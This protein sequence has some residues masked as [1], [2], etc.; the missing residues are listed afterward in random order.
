MSHS[1]MVRIPPH[2][3]VPVTP[4]VRRVID[5]PEMRRLSR[6]SQLGMVSLVYPG[7]THSRFEHSLG[8]YHEAI[9]LID[10]FRDDPFFQKNIDDRWTDAFT[11]ASLVHDIGH[12]PFCHPIEDMQLGGLPRHE[13]R[14]K[15]ILA[16][17]EWSDAIG[18]DWGCELQDVLDLLAPTETSKA[19]ASDACR[20]LTSCLSGPIDVDKLDY[21]QRDS[22]HAGVPYGRH[23]DSD[24]LKSSMTVHPH[25][26]QLAISEKGKTAAE[27]M[28]FSRYVMFSEVYW[29]RTVRAA[30][31]MLQ[32]AVFLLQNRVDLPASLSLD[33]SQW[34]TMIRRAAEGSVAGPMV[35][36]LFGHRRRLYK[37]IAEFDIL[38][39]TQVH[40]L[41]SRRPYWY[42][43][44][45]AE[46]IAE[47]LSS[48]T[49][50]PIHAADVLIDAPPVKLEVDINMDVVSKDGASVKTLGDVS[51][52]A[53][54]LAQ[55]QFDK[56]VK[57]VRIFLR[58]DLRDELR[59]QLEKID[60]QELVLRVTES[61]DVSLA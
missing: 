56:H 36:G 8:V 29:H 61:L 20:F 7:A 39:G 5:M 54:S 17:S 43:V 3:N 33:D 37:Q 1:S 10:R 53:R 59:P 16:K 19:T 57:R 34:I 2:N 24:R 14:I 58:D 11:L 50:C 41:L 60:W 6:L 30:T 55:D 26:P 49:Q 18:Q 46:A 44:A 32:R 51:P 27:M 52:V 48:I 9:Q 21:L 25:R 35:E 38:D 47:S 4:R 40:L 45:A 23:F 13:T 28:V 31:A 12:W 15:Q 42:L 22:L